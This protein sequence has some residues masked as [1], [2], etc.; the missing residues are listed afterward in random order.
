MPGCRPVFFCWGPA[1]WEAKR[2]RGTAGAG[3]PT[4]FSEVRFAPPSSLALAT[5]FRGANSSHRFRAASPGPP[6]FF[7]VRFAPPSSRT[8]AAPFRGANSSHNFRAAAQCRPAFPRRGL[9]PPPR[10]PLK[11]RS[12]EQNL[13][14]N[15]A[16]SPGAGRRTKSTL[17]VY[18]QGASLSSTVPPQVPV[19]R[20]TFN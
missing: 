6:G 2:A 12:G 7:K 15:S 14:S 11:F 13:Q 4:A 1:R 20:G 8:L 3:P 18:R 19:P 17:P 9:L 10:E 5:P 16:L